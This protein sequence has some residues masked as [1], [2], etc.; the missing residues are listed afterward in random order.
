MVNLDT[1]SFRVSH[2]DQSSNTSL[3]DFTDVYSLRIL[4]SDMLEENWDRLGRDENINEYSMRK[5]CGTIQV[6]GKNLQ[7]LSDMLL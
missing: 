5:H 6:Q 3:F 4:F 1:L 2:R 7:F